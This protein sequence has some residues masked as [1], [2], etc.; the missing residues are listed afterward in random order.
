M[1]KF[2]DTQKDKDQKKL[3]QMQSSIWNMAAGINFSPQSYLATAALSQQFAA[4]AV[5]AIRFADTKSPRP[6][7]KNTKFS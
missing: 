6:Y 2:A 7:I 4:N 1:V 5:S 3:Q